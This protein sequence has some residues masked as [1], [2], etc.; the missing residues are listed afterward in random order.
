MLNTGQNIDMVFNFDY[1][2]YSFSCDIGTMTPDQYI[3]MIEIL[4]CKQPKRICEL[5]SGQSTLIFRKYAEENECDIFPI[6]H[7]IC[8]NKRKDCVM[9]ELNNYDFDY[10]YGNCSR[11]VG[12]DKWLEKQDKFDF[13]LIDGPND[14]IPSNYHNVKYSRVQMLDFV[15]LDKLT[16]DAVVLFHDS[17]RNES[18]NTLYEFEKL[19]ANKGIDFKKQ[20]IVESN[21][22]IRKYNEQY[23]DMCPDLTIYEMKKM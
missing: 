22:E 4:E 2:Q 5:G 6:E 15:K 11:Y 9:L 16:D 10:E 18:K 7:D 19:I 23:I 20:I 1:N 13:V 8:Y 17:E 14:V 3:K 12:F 21:N